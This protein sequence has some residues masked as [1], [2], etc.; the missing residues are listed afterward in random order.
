MLLSMISD[1]PMYAYNLQL[2]NKYEEFDVIP[3]SLEKP[4]PFV[5]SKSYKYIKDEDPIDRIERIKDEGEKRINFNEKLACYYSKKRD[6]IAND[7]CDKK[8]LLNAEKESKKNKIFLQDLSIDEK[9]RKVEKIE[10]DYNE[11]LSKLA[12]QQ[13]H[14][15]KKASQKAAYLRSIKKEKINNEIQKQINK[16]EQEENKKPSKFSKFIMNFGFNNSF[17]YRSLN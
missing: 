9:N 6:T 8:S 1:N 7:I 16:V 11:K 15:L 17:N 13:I 4:L 2:Q 12:D 5:S 14:K 3:T 10:N